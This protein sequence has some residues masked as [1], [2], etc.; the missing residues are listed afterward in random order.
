MNTDKQTRTDMQEGF[1]RVAHGVTHKELDAL[2]EKDVLYSLAKGKYGEPG[3]TS[4]EIVL[5][6]LSFKDIE[7]AE[8]N[9]STSRKALSTSRWALTIAISAMALSAIV[10]RAHIASFVTWLL[11]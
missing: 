2:P 5:S 6:W 10:N 3:S 1:D 11:P 4:H 7:R 8:K 9:V